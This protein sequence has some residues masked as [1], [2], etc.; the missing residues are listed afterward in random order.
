MHT[1]NCGSTAVVCKQTCKLTKERN[2]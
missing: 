2:K 1:A